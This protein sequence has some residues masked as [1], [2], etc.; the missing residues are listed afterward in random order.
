MPSALV[1]E[2]QPGSAH[3]RGE[4]A[5]GILEVVVDYNEIKLRRVAHLRRGRGESTADGVFA[6]FAAR[7]EAPLELLGRWREEEHADRVGE[8]PSHL[9]C[10]LPVDLEQDVAAARP[11]VGDLLLRGGVEIAVHFGALEEL[12]G[13]AHAPEG[14]AI[15]EVVLP[16]VRFARARRPRG[17][18][19]RQHELAV[20]GEHRVHERRLP[21][22][23]R[24]SDDEEEPVHSEH[25]KPGGVNG[26]H[27]RGPATLRAKRHLRTRRVDRSADRFATTCA[28]A[29]L[30]PA[31][32]ES[33]PLCAQM[34]C[35]FQYAILLR[36]R[37]STSRYTRRLRRT[38][39]APR[40]Q[41]VVIR[42]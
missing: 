25:A 16:A 22:A 24:R 2:A 34:A 1:R 13:L 12:A 20:V 21:G 41:A 9:L 7:T 33:M 5:P 15:D 30:R 11:N 17:V 10:A 26:E 28:T 38:P 36:Y 42:P 8:E 27:R 4:V 18:G 14:R 31:S 3:H 19:D 23:R 40:D 6:V 39:S 35:Y 37:G 32:L 29:H